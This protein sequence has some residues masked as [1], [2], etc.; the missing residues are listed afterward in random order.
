MNRAAPDGASNAPTWLLL[1]LVLGA[2]GA[3]GYFAFYDT[4][5][6]GDANTPPVAVSRTE[7]VPVNTAEPSPSPRPLPSPPR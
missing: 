1:A 2:I 3:V 6:E 4:G 5:R 7:A